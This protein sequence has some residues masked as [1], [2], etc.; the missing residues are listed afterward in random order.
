[1]N[2]DLVIIS[3]MLVN[4][5]LFI[6]YL[7][8]VP[9]EAPDKNV[10]MNNISLVI[11][12]SALI[13]G[14]I[15]GLSDNLFNAGNWVIL[16]SVVRELKALADN[17]SRTYERQ[18]S[19]AAVALRVLSER[20]IK[21]SAIN[22][23]V[24]ADEALVS[25]CLKNKDTSILLSL[26]KA[27]VNQAETLGVFCMNFDKHLEVMKPVLNKGDIISV[28]IVGKGNKSDVA[29][30][31][32]KWGELVMVKNGSKYIGKTRACAV[33]DIESGRVD[34]TIIVSI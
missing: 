21:A 7:W 18:R 17:K 1:M 23:Q 3:L 27:L 12:T 26:D 20:G 25:Y 6:K 2:L 34:R 32:T 19:N 13:D 28:K 8:R 14:R 33:S 11:D 31:S 29:V 22:S 16:E 10:S 30:G 15:F 5:G 4:I 9:S 24:E